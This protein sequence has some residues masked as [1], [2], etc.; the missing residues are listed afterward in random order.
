MGE[1]N[2]R[3]PNHQ[4]A[5]EHEDLSLASHP[6]YSPNGLWVQITCGV[7]HRR[8]VSRARWEQEVERRASAPRR[9]A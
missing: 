1:E 3:Y 8:S 5:C 9:P 7:G 2:S 6:V 4:C